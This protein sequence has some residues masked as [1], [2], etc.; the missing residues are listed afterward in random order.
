MNHT[1]EVLIGVIIALVAITLMVGIVM[2][3]LG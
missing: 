3:S 1:L 2:T